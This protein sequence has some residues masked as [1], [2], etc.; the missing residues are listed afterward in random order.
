MAEP[1]GQTV[2]FSRSGDRTVAWAAVGTGPPLVVGGWWMSHLELNWA[3]PDFR[4]FVRALA[5]RHT[6][7]RYDRPGSGLSPGAP[8][9]TLD[10]EVAALAQVLTTLDRGPVTLLG[11][12]SGGP[13]AAALAARRPDLVERLVLYG[14]YA[15]GSRIAPP[16][17]RDQLVALVG[18]H[19]GLGSRVLADLFLP[20]AD[21]AERDAFARFQRAS[22]TAGAASASLAATYAFDVRAALGRITVP[23]LVLHRREDRAIAAALGREVAATVPGAAFVALE[24]TD[25]FPWRGDADAV[26]RAVL[27]LPGSSSPGPAP[28]SSV[29]APTSVLSPR[30]LEV[31]RL[32]AGGRSDREI[33]RRLGLSPHT[34]HRHLANIRTKLDL[35]SR[36]AATAYATRH[37]L[38]EP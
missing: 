30:E 16:A 31:L 29:A 8:D 28:E 22:A 10:G 34:V 33:A 32:V 25:H 19:W 6:V 18:A 21:A 37:H 12:S 3:D 4:A 2:R 9:R 27:G 17:V 7:V 5:E 11:A 1:A 15:D 36:A 35:P 24:G 38:L 20:G 23:T 14:T 13:V 26:R